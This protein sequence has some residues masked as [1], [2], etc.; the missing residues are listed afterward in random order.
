M[1]GLH[2]PRRLRAA[3]RASEAADAIGL[4]YRHSRERLWKILREGQPEPPPSERLQQLLDMGKLHEQLAEDCWR[5]RMPLELICTQRTAYRSTPFGEL[6]STCDGE[7]E[8]MVVEFKCTENLPERAK[9]AH[10]AQSV[11]QMFVTSKR[12]AALMYY[13]PREGTFRVFFLL[14]HAEAM[15][16]YLNWIWEFLRGGNLRMPPGARAAREN[17][18][19]LFIVPIAGMLYPSVR[20]RVGN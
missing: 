3:L 20:V 6:A 17:T 2:D 19:E 9:P 13:C 7:T 10:L 4:C 14:W 11:M 15:Q 12:K 16:L 18:L 1:A 5:N 8:D